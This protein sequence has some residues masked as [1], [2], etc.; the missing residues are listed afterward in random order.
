MRF[1]T[2]FQVSRRLRSVEYVNCC[3]AVREAES[4]P[5]LRGELS[6]C[7]IVVK[8]AGILC[9]LLARYAD[10]FQGAAVILNGEIDRAARVKKIRNVAV[11]LAEGHDGH[12]LGLPAFLS[13]GDRK[14]VV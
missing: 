2:L 13:D 14:S 10:D 3:E 7:F 1:V 8:C 5:G 4:W 6:R 11:A 9:G 12:R